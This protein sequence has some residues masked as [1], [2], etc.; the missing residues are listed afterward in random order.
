MPWKHP[1]T[2]PRPPC[3]TWLTS[4][5]PPACSLAA[6]VPPRSATPT[7]PSPT[8]TAA[9]PA[10]A[11]SLLC[12]GTTTRSNRLLAGTS[13][14]PAP[15]SSPGPRLQGAVTQADGGSW[16]ATDTTPLFLQPR[17]QPAASRTLGSR[18][19]DSRYL[20]AAMT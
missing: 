8:T 16:T 5:T 14:N 17:L 10:C 7:T 18:G 20:I 11:I 4:G 6:A 2:G 12:A 9:R 3:V 19:Q 1:P 13:T 15:A